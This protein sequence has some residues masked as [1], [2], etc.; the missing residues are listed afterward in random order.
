MRNDREL[1][2]AVLAVMLGEKEKQVDEALSAKQKKIA[3]LAGD[4][5]KIDA[6]DLA[7]LRGEEAEARVAD[8]ILKKLRSEEYSEE[9]LD[10]IEQA[11]NEGWDDMIKAAK[12]RQKPQPNGGAGVKQGRSYGGSKQKD[13]KEPV[14]EDTEVLSQEESER[15]ADIAKDLGL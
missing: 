1:Q 13:E 14:K 12:E 10:L 8:A 3:K 4:P 15:V 9:E 2:K 7:K 5:E 6:A 11:I